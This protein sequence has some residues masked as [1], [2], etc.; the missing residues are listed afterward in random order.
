MS[1]L[2]ILGAGVEKTLGV[3]MP[4]ANELGQID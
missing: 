2:L 4:L 1:N 3:D